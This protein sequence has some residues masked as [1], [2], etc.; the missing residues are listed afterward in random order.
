MFTPEP[1]QGRLQE[2]LINETVRVAQ[3]EGGGGLTFCHLWFAKRN[4]HS[5]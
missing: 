5:I 4:K 1:L 3:S 2:S